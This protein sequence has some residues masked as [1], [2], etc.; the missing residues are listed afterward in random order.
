[1]T[2]A[3]QIL[4]DH[5]TP[6]VTC[7]VDGC[8]RGGKIVRGMCLAH[9]DW[10]RNHGTTDMPWF[11]RTPAERLSARLLRM[12]NGCLEWTGPRE[13]D[14]YGRIYFD[15]KTVRTHCLAW[16]LANGPIPAGLVIRHFVCD[17]PPCC[18]PDH[19]RSGTVADNNADM[20]AKG[21]G[22]SGESWNASKT[23]C[24]QSH[25]YDEANTLLRGPEHTAR[26]CRMCV[27]AN[28]RRR[29]AARSLV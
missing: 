11:P 22:R 8:E 18:D 17:N 29:R 13:P 19:L 23:N 14:G 20:T 10:L 1:M 3:L 21:R 27:N 7:S 2:R 26:A 24:P 4:V 25:P 6:P 12:P 9:Y 15:G 5:L 16:I 28:K